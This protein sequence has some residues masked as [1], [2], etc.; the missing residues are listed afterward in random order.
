ML[1]LVTSLTAKGAA[2]GPCLWF[3]RASCSCCRE[4]RHLGLRFL[5]RRESVVERCMLRS[6]LYV[7]LRKPGAAV[8][9]NV[10]PITCKLGIMSVFAACVTCLLNANFLKACLKS[11]LKKKKRRFSFIF[12]RVVF[13]LFI[14]VVTVIFELS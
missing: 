6:E 9:L 14:L 10:F 8:T 1:C 13:F 3:R 5:A 11:G 7:C 4:I 2:G 12:R